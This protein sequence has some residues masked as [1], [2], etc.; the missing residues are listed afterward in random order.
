MDVGRSSLYNCMVNFLPEENYFL[1]AF[2][3]LQEHLDDGRDAQAIRLKEFFCNPPQFPPDQITR[4]NSL[5]GI[6]FYALLELLFNLSVFVIFFRWNQLRFP[7]SENFYSRR[8]EV[9]V[10]RKRL[11][12]VIHFAFFSLF[13]CR[14]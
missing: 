5:R 12:G 7:V 10:Y 4:F 13:L 9:L 11:Y 6:N 8:S 2:E 3:L 1:T 14:L